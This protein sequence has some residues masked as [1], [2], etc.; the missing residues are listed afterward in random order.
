MT[1][2]QD[3]EK[4]EKER[5]DLFYEYLKK[6]RDNNQLDN[7]NVHKELASEADRLDIKQKAPLVLAELL[8]SANIIAEVKKH[9]N[10][11]L[12]FTHDDTKAQKYLLAGLEQHICLHADK[13]ME[14]VPGILKV[15]TVCL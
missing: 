1:I 6:R 11:L 9:R 10:L 14:K 12:R 7:L 15:K 3:T 13:L 2:S 4:S 5:L 8:F